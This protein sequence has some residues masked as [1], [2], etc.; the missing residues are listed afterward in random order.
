MS[1]EN[2]VIKRGINKCWGWVGCKTKGY[3]MFSHNGK[4]TRA[5]RYSYQIHKG[6]IPKGMLVCHKCDNRECTN[7]KHLFL[8]TH[9]DNIKDCLN[10][11]RNAIGS[12][13]GSAKLKEADIDKIRNMYI[14]GMGCVAISKLY[15]VSTANIWSIVSGNSWGKYKPIKMSMQKKSSMTVI[16]PNCGKLFKSLGYNYHKSKCHKP[17][18][19]K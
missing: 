6:N 12:K 1:F 19:V 9:Q 4:N 14:D 8:G 3:G 2:H 13:N 17:K 15:K 5:H 11:R 18:E 10:K 16:C 7:P